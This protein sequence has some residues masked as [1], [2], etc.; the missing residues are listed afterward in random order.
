MSPW[1]REGT[2][3]VIKE[4]KEVYR[5]FEQAKERI[6]ITSIHRDRRA[7]GLMR[8][9][10]RGN[11]RVKGELYGC[12]H[13]GFQ[14]SEHCAVPA[15]LPR[16]YK[17]KVSSKR[18]PTW[19]P[20]RLRHLRFTPGLVTTVTSR[21]FLLR[22]P[23]PPLTSLSLTVS[24]CLHTASMSASSI[25]SLSLPLSAYWSRCFCYIWNGRRSSG[26]MCSLSKIQVLDCVSIHLDS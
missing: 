21:R 24:Y 26:N 15:D 7:R 10:G 3:G 1:K 19:L 11:H 20:F 16:Q 18:F 9:E 4:R 6:K 23:L 22:L 25:I 12:T 5:C 8:G 17:V 13:P 2:V 14:P